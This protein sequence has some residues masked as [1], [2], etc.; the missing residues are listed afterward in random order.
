MTHQ[1]FLDL[2]LRKTSRATRRSR[3]HG[4]GG[5]RHVDQAAVER[6]KGIDKFKDARNE[7]AK[8]RRRRRCRTRWTRFARRAG[9]G[10]A[11]K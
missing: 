4:N 5:G 7:R 9:S 3:T 6:F 2:V 1:E 8:E 10:P 11:D